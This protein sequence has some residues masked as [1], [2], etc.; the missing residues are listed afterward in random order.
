MRGP[1]GMHAGT[2]V[3]SI[4]DDESVAVALDDRAPDDVVVTHEPRDDIGGRSRGDRQ[5]VGDLLNPGLVHDDDAIGHRERFFLVVRDMDEHEAQLTLEIAELDAHPQLQQAVEVAERF[6]E[7]KRLWL[8]D[9]DARQRDAL[10]LS[11]R[12]RPRL[13]VGERCQADDLERL[14]SQL[15]PFLLPDFLHLESELDV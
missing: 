6:I 5:G 15:P 9:E 3:L 10:L 11:T 1:R 8:R 13:P 2:H 14:E 7:Q 12:E 4:L